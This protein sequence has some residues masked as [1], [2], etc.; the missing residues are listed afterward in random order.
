[1]I[2]IPVSYTHLDVYKRQLLGGL[3]ASLVDLLGPLPGGSDQMDIPVQHG[4]HPAHAGGAAALAVRVH[5]MGFAH[6]QRGAVITMLCQNGK[7]AVDG[8]ADHP[9]R[10]TVKGTAVRRC[11]LYTSPVKEPLQT[12]IKAIDSMIPIGRGQ[13]ELIIG[14]RQTGKTT[15]ASDTIINQKGKDLSLIHIWTSRCPTA[16]TP[17]L[18]L[19]ALQ[20]SISPRS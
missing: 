3:G 13:R 5:D 14:D 16:S 2:V 20:P 7:V 1:M 15:I 18:I 10:L 17:T 4:E 12:G 19:W 9:F 6:T 11:L 8:T